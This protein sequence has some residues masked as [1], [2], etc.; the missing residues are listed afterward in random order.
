MKRFILLAA[1]VLSFW[2]CSTFS[3]SYKLGNQAE[4]NRNWPEAIR[5]YEAAALDNPRE[6]VY[7]LAL[8]RAKYTASLG[9]VLQ[10][11]RLAAEGKIQEALAEYGRARSYDPS[12][13]FLAEEVRRLTEAPPEEEAAAP[14]K[15]E[16]PIK[17]KAAGEPVTLNF[18]QETSLRSLFMALGRSTGVN[19]L[20]DENFRDIPF[21]I[22]LEETTFEQALSALGTATKNFHRIIDDRTT[23][24]VP[25]QPMKRIQYEIN[26]IKTYRL[27]NIRAEEALQPLQQMISSSF[28]AAKVFADKSLNAIIVRD[29]PETVALAGRLLSQW[30]KPRAEVLVDLEIMEVSRVRLRQLGLNF[31][32]NIVGLRYGEPPATSTSSW[33]NL[34]DLDFSQAGNFYLSLPLAFFQFLESDADTRIIAQPRLRG[35]SGEEIKSIVGQKVPIPKTTFAPIAAGGVSQQPITNYDYQDVG[36]DI[37]LTPQVHREN[38]ITLNLWLKITSLAGTGVADIPIITTREV[39]NVLRLKDGETNLLAGLLRDEERKSLTGIPGLKSLPLLGRLFSSEETRLEQTDVILMI[40][41]TI[42]RRVPRTPE[43][44]KALWVDIKETAG[45]TGEAQLP[46][47]YLERELAGRLRPVRPEDIRSEA[48]NQIMLSPAN[49]ELS[50]NRGEFRITVNLQSSQSVGSLSLN[51]SFNSQIIRLKDVTEGPLVK[52]LGQDVPFLKHVD[53]AAGACTIGLSSPDLSKG[54]KAAG[55]LAVLLF[56]TVS[57]GETQIAVSGVTANGPGGQVISFTTRNA[58]VVVR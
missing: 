44:N 23:I 32:Q 20:F 10:A 14:E 40:T 27:S 8:S 18:P 5:L 35:V 3:H 34:K 2:G 7:R 43:D 55:N 56:E 36:I 26:A 22:T 38:E 30:D 48:E 9:H 11:R 45:A 54:I 47:E 16:L 49:F 6:P 57:A 13:R 19:I 42:I 41:P 50:R 1:V 17:L 37:T 4:L 31:D 51:L 46:E 29:T 28:K 39:K 12:N 33:V 24:I 15:L 52:Q 58:R 53:N 21:A 25:D